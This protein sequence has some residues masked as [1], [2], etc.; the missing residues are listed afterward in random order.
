M[1][2]TACGRDVAV[3]SLL[4]P[5]SAVPVVVSRRSDQAPWWWTLVGRGEPMSKC[6]FLSRHSYERRRNIATEEKRDA[7]HTDV[8]YEPF[9]IFRS[10]RSQ[11]CSL[12]GSLSALHAGG[13]GRGHIQEWRR[14]WA[15]GN[16]NDGPRSKRQARGAARSYADTKEQLGGFFIIEAPDLD[17]ALDWAARYPAGPSGVVEVRPNISGPPDK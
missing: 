5:D 4:F 12:L 2:C 14:P 16:C 17:T 1:I 8:L 6:P 3:L 9:R 13:K 11:E 7:I 15:V 10:N